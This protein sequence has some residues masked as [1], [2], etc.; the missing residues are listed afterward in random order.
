MRADINGIRSDFPILPLRIR[1]ENEVAFG[2]ADQTR[3]WLILVLYPQTVQIYT[4]FSS[5]Q[6]DT[7][8]TRMGMQ[9]L[10]P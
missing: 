2:R 4:H 7:D 3:T 9:I 5:P 6:M 10:H 8:K 1:R